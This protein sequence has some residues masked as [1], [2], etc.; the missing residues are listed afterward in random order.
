MNKRNFF[1][2]I[3]MWNTSFTVVWDLKIKG[4]SGKEIYSLY[5][6]PNLNTHWGQAGAAVEWW[7]A[8]TRVDLTEWKRGQHDP[9]H[10]GEA[11]CRPNFTSFS[12]FLRET[13]KSRFLYEDSKILNVG[14]K[15][16]NRCTISVCFTCISGQMHIDLKPLIFT[17]LCLRICILRAC[18][19]V[20]VCLCMNCMLLLQSLPC[21]NWE[22][23]GGKLYSGGG[24]LSTGW[25][26]GKIL[27]DVSLE[28]CVKHIELFLNLQIFFS[29]IRLFVFANWHP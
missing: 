13:W 3:V 22:E 27:E 12:S 18:V 29:V 25:A 26:G 14:S 24:F 5:I 11:K 15:F 28:G 23:Q 21:G 7:G 1:F 19:C 2:C 9:F 4:H 20:F 16:K 17:L 8:R 10:R 6:R